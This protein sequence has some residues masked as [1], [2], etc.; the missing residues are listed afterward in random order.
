MAVCGCCNQEMTD[1]KTVACTGNALIIFWKFHKAVAPIPF[2]SNDPNA[3]C[4][5]CGVAVG[6]AH[7]P[8]CDME[9]C[10]ICLGQL[11]TCGC[12]DEE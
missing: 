7:H 1:P 4:H 8:G 9:I 3:R 11:I 10:P 6:S 2:M 5:D 12:L